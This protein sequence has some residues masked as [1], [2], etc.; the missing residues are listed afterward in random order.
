[1]GD[2]CFSCPGQA[3]ENLTQAALLHNIDP[4]LLLEAFQAR[5]S[6]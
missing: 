2:G 1:M 3:K 5:L 6:G 4:A